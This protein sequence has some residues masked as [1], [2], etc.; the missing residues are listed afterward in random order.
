[1]I[2]MTILRLIMNQREF[3]FVQDQNEKSHYDH[4]PLNLKGITN[5]K[6]LLLQ[7]KYSKN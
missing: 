6:E 5:Y 1:M 4:I 3:R 2:V 7:A